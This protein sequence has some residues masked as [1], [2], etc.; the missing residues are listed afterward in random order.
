MHLA[1]TISFTKSRLELFAKQA[2]TVRQIQERVREKFSS[3]QKKLHLLQE[4]E[5]RRKK[6][7][8]LLRTIKE[9]HGT[10]AAKAI[11]EAWKKG[12]IKL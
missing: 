2:H 4:A 9:E 7:I 10:K 3:E 12:E 8:H 1:H 6:R 5:I 11:Y